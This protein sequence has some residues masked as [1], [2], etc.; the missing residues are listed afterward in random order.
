MTKLI[1]FPNFQK[2][3][4]L[5]NSP[6][7]PNLLVEIVYGL[8]NRDCRGMGICKINHATETDLSINTNTICGSSFAYLHLEKETVIRLRFLRRTISASQ[9]ERRFQSGY[10]L[11]E[12][13]YVF[14]EEWR[15]FLDIDEVQLEAG[16]YPVQFSDAY[17]QVDLLLT[18]RP[19]SSSI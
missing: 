3:V 6:E 9:Y 4:H 8:I 12:E 5:T 7:V 1:H 11:L 16:V 14:T 2:R 13:P 10:F 19:R 18:K 17:L 15:T